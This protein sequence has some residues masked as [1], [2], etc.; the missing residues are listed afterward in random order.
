MTARRRPVLVL[1]TVALLLPVAVAVAANRPAARH[2]TCAPA[3]HAGGE[4][5][6][7]GH[8]LSNTRSQPAEHTL[9]TTM[10]PT[11]HKAFAFSA[12][13]AGGDGDFTGTPVIAD[14]CL[15]IASTT[16]WVFAANADTGQP[17]WSSLVAKGDEITSTP[18]VGEGQVFVAVGRTGAPYVASL[19]ERTGAVRW[20]TVTD[21]QKGADAYGSPV[22]FDGALFE[23]VSGGSAELSNENERYAFQG[24][25][26]LIETRGRHAG[27]ILKKVYTVQRPSKQ[28]KQGGATVWSTPAVDVRD[29]VAFVGTGNPFHPQT[30]TPHADAILKIDLD[31]HSRRFGDIIGVYD[32]TPEEYQTAAQQLPCVDIPGNP[33]PYYPQGAGAC[34]DMDLDFGASP[35]LV[36]A[37]GRL[38]VGAGQKSGYYHLV[39]ART[40]KGVW[41]TLVGPPS[42]LGGIVG[43]TAYDGKAIYGPITLGGYLWSLDRAT[44]MQRW[45]APVADGAHWGDPVA[46]ADGVVYSVGLTGFLDAYDA[47]TGVPLLHHWMGADV[48]SGDL[49]ASWGGVSIARNT[50]YASIGMTGLA[51][52]YVIGYRAG[53][54]LGG[55][56]TQPSRLQTAP[57][58]APTV[59]AGPQAQSYGYLTPYLVVQKGGALQFANFDLVRHNVVQD[60]S[61]DH[62]ARRTKASWCSRW[63]VRHHSCPLFWSRL[64]GVNASEPVLGVSGL[65]PGTYTFYCTLHPGMRGKLLVTG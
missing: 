39:D 58:A 5:R 47:G 57:G 11:L 22:V 33:A 26:V 7:Y 29:K 6:S 21:R 62:V 48:A 61:A 23:G 49:A 9:T 60:P 19:D 31:R 30:D 36:R 2:A 52:G 56:P 63:Q 44:G 3:R 25:Y 40:M 32:G 4:W 41:H 45:A 37:G 54:P 64:I 17:V 53:A 59:L 51:N 42:S 1:A 34:G 14:G 24:G 65:K 28:A 15:F 12:A 13:D 38:L 10:V 50:V 55:A 8:D 43:S 16:G 46:V 27:R 35:N 18:F 20:R